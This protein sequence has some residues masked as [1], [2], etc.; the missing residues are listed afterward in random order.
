MRKTCGSD[1]AAER[2]AAI[3]R[4]EEDHG[5]A[6]PCNTPQRHPSH[7]TDRAAA[8]LL[9]SFSFSASVSTVELAL[10]VVLSVSVRL[11]LSVLTELSLRLSACLSLS[12]SHA[13]IH[14]AGH[15]V[16]SFRPP[17]AGHHLLARA[18]VQSRSSTGNC[19]HARPARRSAPEQ[20]RN[21]GVF[22]GI[23]LAEARGSP[24]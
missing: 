10:S 19:S 1:L 12:V 4:C 21:C 11:S 20:K 3:S 22:C 5:H 17:A 2:M 14:A 24:D 18:C 23:F 16:L 8:I 13:R 7:A 9:R 15:G 6:A